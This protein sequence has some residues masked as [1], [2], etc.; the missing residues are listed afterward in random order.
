[1]LTLLLVLNLVLAAYLCGVVWMVQLVQYPAFGLVPKAAW[2]AFHA[3]HSRRMGWV[4]G[5]PMVAEL[6]L[7]L[8]LAWVGRHE[9]PGSGPFWA[10]AL[11]AVVWA[12]TFFIAV[13]FHRRLSEGFDYIAI[14]GLTRTNWLRT[15]AWTFRV[16][17]LGALLL[18]D[19]NAKQEAGRVAP[20]PLASAKPSRRV[21]FNP[22]VPISCSARKRAGAR[23]CSCSPVLHTAS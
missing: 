13:P 1:M 14:D 4:V 2:G 21:L 3:A 15:L 7:A 9:L 10:L 11:V 22:V 5:A 18:S 12:A 17:L 23:C 20:R 8:A 6:A 19:I 16:G